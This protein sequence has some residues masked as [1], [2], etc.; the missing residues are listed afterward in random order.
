MTN[1]LVPFTKVDIFVNVISRIFAYKNL[2]YLAPNKVM[3]LFFKKYVDGSTTSRP[4]RACNIPL[5][6]SIFNFEPFLSRISSKEWTQYAIEITRKL[7]I[8]PFVIRGY[9]VGFTCLI[10]DVTLR[11][12]LS[13]FSFAIIRSKK[14][15]K[16][17]SN[18]CFHATTLPC[19]KGPFNP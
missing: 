16:C 18:K 17:Y 8:F 12:C 3:S 19:S 14:T 4:S 7:L 1:Q 2:P 15:S 11:W 10:I 5:T 13:T 9:I 6:Y